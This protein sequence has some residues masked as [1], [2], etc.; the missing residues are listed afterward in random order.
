M[1]TRRAKK[2]ASEK[3][4]D[5]PPK[6][7]ILSPQHKEQGWEIRC[8]DGVWCVVRTYGKIFLEVDLTDKF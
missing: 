1:I 5:F 2:R 8:L 4:V 6:D 7:L 3:S